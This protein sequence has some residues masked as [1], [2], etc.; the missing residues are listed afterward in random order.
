MTWFQ[1]SLGSV[2]FPSASSLRL[3]E[4]VI[5]PGWQAEDALDW[6]TFSLAALAAPVRE[7]MLQIYSDILFAEAFGVAMTQRLAELAPA[8]WLRAFAV[9]QVADEKRHVQFFSRVVGASAP[10][11]G[12]SPWLRRVE[13]EVDSVRD[14]DELM[15]HAQIIEL[16]AQALFVFNAKRSLALLSS[17][18]RLP[19]QHVVSELLSCLIRNVGQDESRHIAFGHHYLREAMASLSPHRKQ[20][21]A[22]RATSTA[23]LMYDAFE[24]RA[25][26]F[27]RL[28]LAMGPMQRR[29]FDSVTTQVRALGLEIE[30]PSSRLATNAALDV[31]GRGSVGSC[32][33]REV[34]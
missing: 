28:G 9:A 6:R 31:S 18:I 29:V 7:A 21:L 20:E 25:P 12:V 34:G 22:R 24:Y 19:G 11:E 8:G 30:A 27:A 17:G 32:T 4:S 15:L 2:R 23:Q 33:A 26:S 3:Y 1:T 10:T 14:Y 5:R 13:E 16:S